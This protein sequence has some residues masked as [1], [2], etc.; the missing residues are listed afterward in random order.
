LSLMK[1]LVEV[2]QVVGYGEILRTH[3]SSTLMSTLKRITDPKLRLVTIRERSEVYA[4]LK[5]VFS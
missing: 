4:T 2:S 1:R 3:Y 5:T